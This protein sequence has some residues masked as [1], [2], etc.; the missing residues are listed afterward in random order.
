M[1]HK[2]PSHMRRMLRERLKGKARP[3]DAEVAADLRGSMEG[4]LGWVMPVAHGTLTWQ[5][6][7]SF[8]QHF[9][10][11]TRLLRVQTLFCAKQD[12]TEMVILELLVGLS[13]IVRPV[14]AP[15]YEG[16]DGARWRNWVAGG[17]LSEPWTGFT[18]ES[19]QRR[20]ALGAAAAEGTNGSVTGVE[21]DREG[22]PQRLPQQSPAM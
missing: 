13:Y 5:Q 22:G 21:A 14:G 15:A 9:Q 19:R 10:R 20:R 7:H 6:E 11:R 4:M 1:Y 3:F 17:G 12:L 8:G 16:A 2:A 18:L